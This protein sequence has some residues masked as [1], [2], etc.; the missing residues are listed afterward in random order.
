[1]TPW[2]H[3]VLELY[4]H[5]GVLLGG[6]SRY[7]ISGGWNYWWKLFHLRKVN[8]SHCQKVRPNGNAQDNP[9]PNW[10]ENVLICWY[11]ASYIMTVVWKYSNYCTR[12]WWSVIIV[13]MKMAILRVITNIPKFKHTHVSKPSHLFGVY[14]T[15]HSLHLARSCSLGIARAS[16]TRS[17]T[18][19]KTRHHVGSSRHFRKW[20]SKHKQHIAV[21]Q[22]LVP[23]VNI[24]IAGKWMF[25]PLKMVLIGIDPYP[26][27]GS[28]YRGVA[29]V[30][31]F[32]GKWVLTKCLDPSGLTDETALEATVPWCS[33]QLV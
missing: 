27:Y 7:L 24:K 16:W 19:P 18:P 22:N 21:C 8:V 3:F 13:P 1:M 9:N 20:K 14:P 31:E 5:L 11:G 29:G 4:I 30:Y 28:K 32:K 25:I 15:S 26:Y 23:L 33:L 12:P 10:T 2:Y 6:L 17:F